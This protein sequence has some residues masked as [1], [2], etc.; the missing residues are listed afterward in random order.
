MFN[1]GWKRS[2]I[3]EGIVLLLILLAS[4]V[5]NGKEI[6][7]GVIDSGYNNTS[8][9]KLCS[10]GHYDT[11]SEQYGIGKDEKGH[12]T[13]VAEIIDYYSNKNYC[14]LVFKV[15]SKT[16]GDSGNV[17]N[18]IYKAIDAKVDV[19]NLSINSVHAM[20]APEYSALWVATHKGI[21]VFF[22]SGNDNQNLDENCN[23]YPV[24]YTGTG[25]VFVGSK[26]SK[27]VKN[28]ANYGKVVTQEEDFCYDNFCGSSAST[29]I[30][31]GKWV[32]NH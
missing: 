20:Y 26:N 19:I 24:C 32:G 6:R 14:I 3:R 30:A 11:I 27:N 10:T 17:V 16:K 5:A 4:I 12:G 21:K 13:K 31:T 9:V 18:A 23:L 7:V 22:A 8:S 28:Q 2:G 25:V 1:K 15:F 29:A